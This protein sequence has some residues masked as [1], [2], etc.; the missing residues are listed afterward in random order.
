M[1]DDSILR[2]VARSKHD[3]GNA[4]RVGMSRAAATVGG[5]GTLA[6]RIGASVG[7]VNNALT[8]KT[9]P[10]FHT[11][12]NLLA[13]DK[14]ALDEVAAL[15]NK[16]LVRR[17]AICSDDGRSA[18]PAIVSALAKLIQAEADGELNHGE[19]LDM[20][21]ELRTARREID[22]LLARIEAIRGVVSL[23]IRGRVA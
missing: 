2:N 1:A 6:D 7:T 16:R 18:A 8:G 3:V 22:V 21:P 14:T 17:E 4:L 11:G 9:L 23:P 20:E 5:T 13:A 12:W 10:E 15:Y 19:M